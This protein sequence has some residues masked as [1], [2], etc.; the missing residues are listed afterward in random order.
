V[1]AEQSRA[2]ASVVDTARSMRAE[3]L[4]ARERARQLMIEDRARRQRLDDLRRR[5]DRA[6]PSRVEGLRP[7]GRP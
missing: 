1:Q 7:R 5:I 4:A 6:G 2:L 3:A